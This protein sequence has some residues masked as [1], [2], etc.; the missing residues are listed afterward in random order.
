[1]GKLQDSGARMIFKTGA[2]RDLQTGKGAFHLIPYESLLNLARHFENGAEKYSPRNWEKGVP[3]HSFFD[4]CIRHAFQA[5]MGLDDEDHVSAVA[6]NIQGFKWTLVRIID[7][8]LP[9]K[10]ADKDECHPDL[11]AYIK[12]ERSKK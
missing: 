2:V 10:L 1:M 12:R 11:I 6:W 5:W 3:L 8:R 9:M 4:S 7:G